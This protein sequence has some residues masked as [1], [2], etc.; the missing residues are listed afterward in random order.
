M[1]DN[2][3][4]RGCRVLTTTLHYINGRYFDEDGAPSTPQ[5][6]Q[7]ERNYRNDHLVRLD[8]TTELSDEHEQPIDEDQVCDVHDR[9]YNQGSGVV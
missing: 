8:D 1:L 5:D 7:L 9:A 3:A 2:E 6:H 4:R